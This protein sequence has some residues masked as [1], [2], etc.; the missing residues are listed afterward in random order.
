MRPRHAIVSSLP[1][2]RYTLRSLMRSPGFAL[3]TICTLALAIGANTA[4]FSLAYTVMF[5]PLPVRSPGELIEMLHQ[6]P[7]SGEP[8]VNG[9]PFATYQ[10]LRDNNRVLSGLIATSWRGHSGFTVQREGAEPEQVDGRY[11]NG[12]YFDLLGL[13]PSM[14]RLL[15]PDDDAREGRAPAAVAVLSW[16]SWRNRFRAHPEIL[17]KH[18]L[19]EQLP[20]TIIGVAP[21]SFHGV[22][23]SKAA[24]FWMPLSLAS[25]VQPDGAPP[26]VALLG[27]LPPGVSLHRA[28][29]E[30]E[31]LYRQSWSDADFKR[32]PNLQRMQFFVQPAASG[33]GSVKHR[34][35]KPLLL[36][37]AAVGLLLLVACT[38]LAN[39]M[40]AR[41]EARQREL[42]IRSSLGSGAARLLQQVL[43]ECFAIAALGA[44]AGILLA[45]LGTGALEHIIATAR[46]HERVELAVPF[47]LPVLLFTGIVAIVATVLFGTAPAWRAIRVAPAA[48]LRGS[49]NTGRSPRESWIGS[50]LVIAQVAMSLVLLSTAVLFARHLFELRNR[51][52]GFEP[53]RILVVSLDPSQSGLDGAR[54]LHAY[55]NLIAQLVAIPGVESASLSGATPISGAGASRFVRAEGFEEDPDHRRYASLNWVSPGYFATYQT[56]VLAG[57]EFEPADQG[58]PPTVVINQSMANFY[59]AGH[60]PIGRH[61]Q[62]VGQDTKYE[63]LGVVTDAKYT[64][65]RGEAPRTCFLLAFQPRRVI[66]GEISLRSALPP[67]RLLPLIRESVR[68]SANGVRIARTTTMSAQM[69]AAIVPERL[70]AMVSR[71]FGVLGLVLT[72]VGLYG[73]LQHRVS[74]RLKE[75]GIRIAVGATRGN[76]SWLLLKDASILVGVGLVLGAAV[77]Y[78]TERLAVRVLDGLSPGDSLPLIVS[79]AIIVVI[80]ALA[81]SAPAWRAATVDPVQSLRAE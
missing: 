35:G 15:R 51:D 7:A 50:G 52:L 4:I 26:G 71:L 3:T 18:I 23:A 78:W 24:E 21:P 34:F 42:A 74:R 36:L 17:G 31:H 9:F 70:V 12:G 53:S 13:Q 67:A 76:V 81:A 48:L 63:I 54:R 59:F 66:G 58:G 57:R 68:E 61:I 62:L 77:S 47:D 43:L 45:W 27:R 40:A 80:T 46:P 73:V 69:D 79:A 11:V 33:I 14:G 30:L 38:N 16:A 22:N 41:G 75:I 1:A 20:V 49:G 29:T 72:A 56:P 64:E 65:L 60:N 39:V 8:R 28:Q 44:V 19:V 32:D 25:Q 37:M 55:Q 5:R 10:H 6:Y 2:L